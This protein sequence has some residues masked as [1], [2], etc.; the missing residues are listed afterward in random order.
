MSLLASRGQL[1]AFRS[2]F[3]V[4]HHYEKLKAAD[5]ALPRIYS[6]TSSRARCLV[7]P[8]LA[9]KYGLEQDNQ[10]LVVSVTNR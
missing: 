5:A 4:A 3:D 8:D 7:G 9:S 6:L 10:Q 1:P 2:V